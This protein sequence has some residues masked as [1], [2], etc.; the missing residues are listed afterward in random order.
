M[1]AP[2]NFG[3]DYTLRFRD[4][5]STIASETGATLVPFLLEGVA[6]VPELNQADGLH[7][8]VAGAA[9]VAENVWRML[10]PVVES[11]SKQS[12]TTDFAPAHIGRAVV[13]RP[14]VGYS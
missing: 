3:L 2:P 13:K 9:R 10:K 11:V 5:Y 14:S 6:A 12:S 7:P 8:N 4:M 1:E